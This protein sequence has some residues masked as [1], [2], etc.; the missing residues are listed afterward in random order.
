MPGD[1]PARVT[2]GGLESELATAKAMLAGILPESMTVTRAELFG[3]EQGSGILLAASPRDAGKVHPSFVIFL[4]PR[5]NSM[6]I[7]YETGAG[8]HTFRP[9]GDSD[10]FRVYYSNTSGFM[11]KEVEATFC[12]R[13]EQ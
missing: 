2:L 10:K 4:W 1:R 6:D 7:A 5:T 12:T 13:K 9:L 3:L 8:A 11:K